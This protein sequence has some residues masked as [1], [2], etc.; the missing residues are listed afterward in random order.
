MRNFVKWLGIIAFA[1]VIGFLFIACKKDALDGTTWNASIRGD[2]YVLTFNSPNY[3][4]TGAESG[5]GTYSVSGD[6]VTMT[7]D[8]R[9][10]Q[11]T[12]SGNTLTY[13]G[14]TFTKQESSPKNSGGG[15]ASALVG[16]W[17]LEPGQPTRGNIEDME[18]LRDGTGIVDGAGITWKVDSGRFY[19]TH[20]LQAAAW[21]Y[22]VSG[23]TL[24]LTND[25]GTSLTYK[26]R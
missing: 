10:L 4:L 6:S 9:T 23:S 11:G 3:T 21:G 20:P 25:N 12:L 2:N 26:K 8:N 7:L 19:V 22:R 24:V 14:L 18:L 13:L 17:S 15:R 5:G 16:R 1:A